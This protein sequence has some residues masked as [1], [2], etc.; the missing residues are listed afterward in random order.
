LSLWLAWNV[1]LLQPVE[2]GGT[3]EAQAPD[4]AVRPGTIA[5]W[6][7][8]WASKRLQTPHGFILSLP[9]RADRRAAEAQVLGQVWAYLRHHVAGRAK[10]P[11]G[12]RRCSID[13]HHQIADEQNRATDGREAAMAVSAIHACILSF[14]GRPYNALLAARDTVW[15]GS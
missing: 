3:P 6:E 7:N 11:D 2:H 8:C 1:E 5:T 14:H 10:S 15:Q 13:A 9:L 4:S 12:R